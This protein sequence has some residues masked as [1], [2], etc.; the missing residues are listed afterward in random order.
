MRCHEYQFNAKTVGNMVVCFTCLTA[1]FNAY[2]MLRTKKV[3]GTYVP[4]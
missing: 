2:N 1:R 4:I 3:E